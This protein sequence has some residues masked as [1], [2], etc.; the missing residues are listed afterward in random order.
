MLKAIAASNKRG[1][2]ILAASGFSRA[3]IGRERSRT[4]R[5]SAQPMSETGTPDFGRRSVRLAGDAHHAGHGLRDQVEA[6]TLRP[7]SG[8]AEPEMLA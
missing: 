5:T 8:L 2:D 7:W 3:D 4:A 1:I 6:G